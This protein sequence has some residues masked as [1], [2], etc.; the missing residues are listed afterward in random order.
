MS[1]DKHGNVWRFRIMYKGK[2]YTTTIECDDKQAKAAHE[3]FKVDVRRGNVGLNENML[4][5]ELSQLVLDNY[6]R[7]NC[8]YNT[9]QLYMTC[10]NNHIVPYFGDMK[11]SNI[12]PLSVQQFVQSLTEKDL[13]SSTI[14][15]IISC[16]RKTFEMAL[17]WELITKN[18]SLYVD[19]PS[20]KKYT[21]RGQIMS[22]EEMKKL[23]YIYE[24][25]TSK[26]SRMHKA[27]FYIAV[28]CGLRNS[29]IRA[30]TLDDIDFENSIIKVT[31]QYGRYKEKGEVKEGYIPTK[32]ESSCRNIYA[33]TFTMNALKEYIDSLDCFPMTKQ[34]FW[35]K[36]T[37]KPI[38]RQCLST[39]LTNLL[40][41]NDLPVI[42]FHDLRHIHATL[43]ASKGVNMKSLSTRMGH[44]KIETTNIYMQPIDDIDKQVASTLDSA[45]TDLKNDRFLKTV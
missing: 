30:L 12:K 28:G 21:N 5:S 14:S 31:K 39:F 7:V 32:S 13:S 23:F 35:S 37:N 22:I 9:E 45:I 19:K 38:G 33:P 8:K 34:L 29:E 15:S 25:L 1:M 26:P 10:Y 44:S 2:P 36:S 17:K 3:A 20:K 6:V 16:L 18:P 41:K 11:I 27:A 42:D 43:L 40:I 4:F 24:D